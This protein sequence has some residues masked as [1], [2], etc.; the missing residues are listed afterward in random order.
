MGNQESADAIEPLTMIY[1]DEYVMLDDTGITINWYFFP[2]G[3]KRILYDDIL[4]VSTDKELG[5]GALDYKT[6]GMGTSKIWW[7]LDKR[8]LQFSPNNPDSI[9]IESKTDWIRKGFA[10]EDVPRVLEILRS[11]TETPNTRVRRFDADF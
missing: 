1:K 3:S 6:W 8:R 5:L 2:G 4:K 9:V 7:A 10:A 11:K